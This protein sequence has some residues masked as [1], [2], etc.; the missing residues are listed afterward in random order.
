MWETMLIGNPRM[1]SCFWGIYPYGQTY[2]EKL[3]PI[4]K[5]TLKSYGQFYDERLANKIPPMVGKLLPGA[6]F[7]RKLYNSKEE[8]EEH[9]IPC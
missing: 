3:W 4:S 1:R 7:P 6:S 5:I 9:E 2:I 8:R